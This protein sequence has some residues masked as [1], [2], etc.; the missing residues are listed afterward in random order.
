MC[1]GEFPLTAASVG[2]VGEAEGVM[3]VWLREDGVIVGVLVPDVGEVVAAVPVPPPVLPPPGE[4][5]WCYGCFWVFLRLILLTAACIGAAEVAGGAASEAGR[6]YSANSKWRVR[7]CLCLGVWLSPIALQLLR[8][9]ELQLE[10]ARMRL[11]MSPTLRGI[12][13]TTACLRVPRRKVCFS[14]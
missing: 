8:T 11:P 12:A 7:D 4:G 13:P 14:K 5:E 2:D 10:L 3:P 6:E 9:R 1:T